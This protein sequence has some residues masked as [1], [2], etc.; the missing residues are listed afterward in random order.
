LRWQESDLG[1]QRTEIRDWFHVRQ[2]SASASN[3]YKWFPLVARDQLLPHH[4]QFAWRTDL[5]HAAT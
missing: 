1:L 4:D 5:L 3:V 2:L